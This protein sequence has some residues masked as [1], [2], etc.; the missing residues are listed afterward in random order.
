MSAVLPHYKIPFFHVFP[1]PS[2]IV[3]SMK[4]PLPYNVYVSVTLTLNKPEARQ[5]ATPLLFCGFLT[6]VSHCSWAY[7]LAHMT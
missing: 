5:E 7:N 2:E 3:F 4:A 1:N 6:A